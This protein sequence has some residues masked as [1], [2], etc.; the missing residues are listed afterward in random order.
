MCASNDSL[1]IY[2]Q[3]RLNFPLFH[4]HFWREISM[5][6]LHRT[7]YSLFLKSDSDIQRTHQKKLMHYFWVKR[8][9]SATYFIIYLR[10]YAC[11]A[12]QNN[13]TVHVFLL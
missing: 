3:A 9:K 12:T 4:L 11:T 8:E 7:L 10:L 2:S 1:E 5:Q 6:F 13:I